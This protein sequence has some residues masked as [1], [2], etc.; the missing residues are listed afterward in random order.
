MTLKHF[1]SELVARTR[2]LVSHCV[3]LERTKAQ[4][5]GSKY[6]LVLGKAIHVKSIANWL[7]AV[8]H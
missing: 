6:P 7:H 8:P 1:T 3:E 5:V 4:L 2:Q